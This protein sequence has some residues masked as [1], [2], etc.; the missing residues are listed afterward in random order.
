MN[1]VKLAVI[2]PW[3]EEKILSILGVSDDVVIDYISN[4]L[5]VQVCK[6][7]QHFGPNFLKFIT[8]ISYRVR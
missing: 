6:F 3:I 7:F 2:K 4:Q 8:L 1:K 5:D